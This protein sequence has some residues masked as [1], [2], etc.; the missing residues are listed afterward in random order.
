M[1]V[2]RSLRQKSREFVF[3][4]FGNGESE[5]PARISF[6]RFPLPDE[7]FPRADQ[8]AVLDSAFMREFD[9]SAKAKERLVDLI[10][11]TMVENI[12]ANRIDFGRFFGEC[13]EKIEDLE[14]DGHCVRS[15]SDFFRLLPEEA[16]YQIALEAY[17]YA[18]E[19]DV[20][21]MAEKKS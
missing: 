18:K 6:S 7:T 16:A 3:G 10:I 14:Y 20:F 12:T 19:G 8:R 5:S 21:S 17:L 2:L 9:G 11:G 4:A 13:V 15:A 1:A